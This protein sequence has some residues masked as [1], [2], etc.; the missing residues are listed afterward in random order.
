MPDVF[1]L[2]AG[3][4]RAISASMPIMR[5]ITKAVSENDCI[6]LPPPLKDV[7]NR[8]QREIEENVELWLTYLYQRQPWLHDHFNELNLRVANR[9]IKYLAERIEAGTHAAVQ[10]PAPHW[11]V[12]LVDQWHQ[13]RATVITLNYDTLVERIACGLG[14]ELAQL[15]ASGSS[16]ETLEYIKLHGSINWH[17]SGEDS[18]SGIW[19]YVDV[20]PWTSQINACD[21][22]VQMLSDTEPLIIPPLTE[23]ATYYENTAIRQLWQRAGDAIDSATRV[24]V[25]GYSLPISDLGM[26]LFLMRSLLNEPTPWYLINTDAKIKCHFKKLLPRYEFIDTF[27]SEQNPTEPFVECYPSLPAL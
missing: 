18:N 26:Q 15:Y 21:S 7:E 12:S 5:D 25:I 1:I 17:S 10:T 2:G 20:T 27:V 14:I 24:F 4:S 11:L 22:D 23:K 8:K 3:F 16:R 19:N 9:I 13:Q 6:D